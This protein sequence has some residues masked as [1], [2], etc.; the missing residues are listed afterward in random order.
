M[1]Y[2]ELCK[3]LTDATDKS[4]EKLY[5]EREA[6]AVAR[7]FLE[8][9]CGFT[10]ADLYN[11][12]DFE[13]ATEEERRS[14]GG[15]TEEHRRDVRQAIDR[16]AVGEP[17][18]YVVGKALFADR[19]FTVRKGVLIP[20]PETAELCD[21]IAEEAKEGDEILDIGTGSGCI[22]IT[23]ALNTKAKVTAWDIADEA[24]TT[25]EENSR[26]L[27]AAVSV[28]RHDI[29]QPTTDERQ[30]DIIVSNPPYICEN[31]KAEMKA[32]VLEHE[33]H[34]ALFVPDDDPLKFYRAIARYAAKTLRK[35]G[36]LFFE[37]NSGFVRELTLMLEADG[38][39]DIEMRCDMYG[40]QRMMRAEVPLPHSG[41]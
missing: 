10:L 12:R 36:R 37:M 41:G 15:A 38:F 33:P 35:G 1:T 28:E 24:L 8:D 4:G 2:Q 7:V 31:E 11:G 25:A 27:K 34:L 19:Y 29:L 13:R 40:R 6:R 17:V 39:T 30:W 18:Q 21:W 14:N 5:D 32:N 23:V 9:F 22:A 26:D 3:L 16:L 20:R